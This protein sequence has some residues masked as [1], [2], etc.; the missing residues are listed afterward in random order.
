MPEMKILKTEAEKKDAL[1]RELHL[2]LTLYRLASPEDRRVIWTILEK[3][4]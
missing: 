4:R 3:Y 2:L 1:V